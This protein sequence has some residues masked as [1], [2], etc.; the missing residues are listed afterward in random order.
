MGERTVGH[1]SSRGLVDSLARLTAPL[2]HDQP[3]GYVRAHAS[4][5]IVAELLERLLV[6][7]PLLVDQ[8]RT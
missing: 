1:T 4:L 8:A 2:L 3:M 7:R 5:G 6:I